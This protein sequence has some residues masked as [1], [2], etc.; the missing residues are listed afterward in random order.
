MHLHKDVDRVC[1]DL[2]DEPASSSSLAV[3]QV[4]KSK[5]KQSG[6]CLA[7]ARDGLSLALNLSKG[8]A[9]VELGSRDVPTWCQIALFL[10]L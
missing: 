4:N 7:N 1:L 5:R 2:G 6:Q 9:T 10:P 8:Q 3:S